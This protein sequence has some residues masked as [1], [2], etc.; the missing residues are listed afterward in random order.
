VLVF[1]IEESL[2][3]GFGENG[4]TRVASKPTRAVSREEVIGP[5][6]QSAR[7]TARK[8]HEAPW[9]TEYAGDGQHGIAPHV[10]YSVQDQHD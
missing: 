3:Q 2:V 8:R 10:R 7:E 5:I 6:P 4:T 9:T 1:V